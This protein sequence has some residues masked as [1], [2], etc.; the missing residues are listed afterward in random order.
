MSRTNAATVPEPHPRDLASEIAARLAGPLGV[1]TEDHLRGAVLLRLLADPGRP[2]TDGEVSAYVWYCRARELPIS[3][4]GGREDPPTPREVYRHPDGSL[5]VEHRT[6]A[7]TAGRQS[8]AAVRIGTGDVVAIARS[9]SRLRRDVEARQPGGRWVVSL[10]I[11]DRSRVMEVWD[12][13]S[14]RA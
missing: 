8:W 10:A 1:R 5:E 7:D 2:P 14:P 13:S 4:K 12:A 6:R 9:W 3:G 11:S